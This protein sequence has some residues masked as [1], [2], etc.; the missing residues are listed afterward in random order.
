M[1]CLTKL[2]IPST[3]AAALSIAGCGGESTP[4][5][6]TAHSEGDGHNHAAPDQAEAV[7]DGHG[8]MRPLG[9][10]VIAGTSLEVSAS[11]APTPNTLM[12]VN[13]EYRDGPAPVAVRLWIGNEAGDESV[14]S[15]ATGTGSVLHG[16]VEVPAEID[17]DAALWIEVETASGERLH[18]SVALD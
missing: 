16:H 8:A 5:D 14:R 12:H 11:G 13:I 7:E 6:S 18:G 10:V 2:I 1:N 4:H 15:R 9:S 17:A 3:L